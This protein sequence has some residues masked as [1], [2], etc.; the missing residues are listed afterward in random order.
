MY[1]LEW[2]KYYTKTES[3]WH[4]ITNDSPLIDFNKPVLLLFLGSI[5]LYYEPHRVLPSGGG[6]PVTELNELCECI[7]VDPVTYTLTEEGRKHLMES[8][9]VAY[10][11]ID[12]SFF[13]AASPYSSCCLS[14]IILPQFGGNLFIVYENGERGFFGGEGYNKDGTFD[15]DNLFSSCLHA[16]EE[17]RTGSPAKTI[18]N[19]DLCR[20]TSPL[21]FI[22][23]VNK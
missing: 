10:M 20:E 2:F 5:I 12:S 11:Y 3:L 15:E 1:K 16:D 4:S 23:K 21:P 13:K 7:A 22:V 9:V 18:F 17:A 19:I 8:E 14:D 6:D